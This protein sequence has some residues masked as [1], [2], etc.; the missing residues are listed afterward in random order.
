MKQVFTSP[1]RIVNASPPVGGSGSVRLGHGYAIPTP[2]SATVCQPRSC[3]AS[4]YTGW[5]TVVY[6]RER[7]MPFFADGNQ[8]LIFIFMFT[9]LY[10]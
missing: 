8:H 6:N 4:P 5:Q 2:H 9:T 3:S 10:L 7:Y 1:N